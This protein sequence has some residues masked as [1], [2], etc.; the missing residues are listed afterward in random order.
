MFPNL[1]AEMSRLGLEQKNI[2]ECIHKGND[3]V[4]LKMN[5]K[6]VWLLD[7]A[8]LIQ[9]TFFPSMTIEYLFET[10]DEKE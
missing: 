10:K 9:K 8:K 1:N 6:R 7:E 3:A 2:A 4:S 5:G